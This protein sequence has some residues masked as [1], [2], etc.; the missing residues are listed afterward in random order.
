MLVTNMANLPIET[1]YGELGLEAVW[2]PWVLPRHAGCPTIGVATVN[3]AL[4]L[5][6]TGYGTLAGLL[7][8]A[9]GV[10]MSATR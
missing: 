7:T 2:G 3:G 1:R 8:A 4:C 6:H 10:L 5:T 9:E